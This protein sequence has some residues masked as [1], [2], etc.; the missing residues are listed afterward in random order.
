AA[1]H[2]RARR[3]GRPRLHAR[4]AGGRRRPGP[5]AAGAVVGGDRRRRHAVPALG[6]AAC[7]PT[8]PLRYAS[9]RPSAGLVKTLP[10]SPYSTN[11]PYRFRSSAVGS[12]VR[13]AVR[14]ETRAACCMLWVT[15]TMV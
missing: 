8:L 10:V 4:R 6:L 13:N 3:A 2:G 7:Q 11:W 14:S 9:V 5:G 1:D 12:T 15:M